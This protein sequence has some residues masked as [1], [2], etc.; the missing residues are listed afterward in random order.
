[1]VSYFI[2]DIHL[3]SLEENSSR[4]LLLFL[5]D[6]WENNP[7]DLYLLGDIF[8]VWV[9]DHSIFIKRYKALV[10]EFKKIKSKGYK[11]VYF[12]GNHDLHLKKFWQDEVGFEVYG[13]VGYFNIQGRV[14]RLEHGDLINLEDHAY[15]RLRRTLR[16]GPITFL[17]HHL[18]G[19][20]WNW[21]GTKWS[22]TSRKNSS[23]YS[24]ERQAEMKELI[25]SHAERAYNEK[26]FDYIITG[27]IHIVD[28]V[29]LSSKARSINLGTWLNGSK[30]LKFENNEVHWI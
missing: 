22:K 3:T 23:S 21:F 4:L 24:Q 25:R 29:V 26:P 28:D 27:H 18:P 9:A 6:T 2:S 10:D 17:A 8:D 30:I 19:E 1:M 5:R 7:G 11:V 16:S 13:D 20:F 14:F 12:E 15:Q